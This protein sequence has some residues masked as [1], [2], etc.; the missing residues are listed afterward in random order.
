VPALAR[1]P[2]A[3]PPKID[4]VPGGTLSPLA[5][6]AAAPVASLRI[7]YGSPPHRPTYALGA[8]V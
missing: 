3:S 5:L 8:S 1:V 6:V 2:G 7:D 4:R